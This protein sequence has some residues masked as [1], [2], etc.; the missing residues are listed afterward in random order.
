[1][2]RKSGKDLKLAI[3]FGET[4]RRLRTPLGLS[5]EALAMLANID[6]AYMGGLERGT[7]VPSLDMVV[8]ISEALGMPSEEV[9]GAVM[10]EYRFKADGT[11]KAQPIQ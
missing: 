9:V 11:N 2:A 5:Q 10:D 6:R 3:A 1:M 7:H 8:R 4:V